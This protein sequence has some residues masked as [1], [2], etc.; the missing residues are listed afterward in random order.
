MGGM[1]HESEFLGN[2]PKTAIWDI[3]PVKFVVVGP[4]PHRAVFSLRTEVGAPAIRV[5]TH[6]LAAW[7]PTRLGFVM[8]DVTHNE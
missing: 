3:T 5:S 4:L 2:W 8:L 7:G 1:C 6:R